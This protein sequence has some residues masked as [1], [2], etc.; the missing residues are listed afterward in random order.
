MLLKS[1]LNMKRFID[2]IT[3]V[4]SVTMSLTQHENSQYL[5]SKKQSV[6]Y[7]LAT[8]QVLKL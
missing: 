6:N 7:R 8:Y 4:A 5:L 2:Y 3:H 1:K